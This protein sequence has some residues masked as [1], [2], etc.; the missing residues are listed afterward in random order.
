MLVISERALA[1]I[2]DHTSMISTREITTIAKI[3]RTQW[4]VIRRMPNC[5][6]PFMDGRIAKFRPDQ[7]AAHL[8]AYNEFALAQS[9]HQ[10]HRTL[11]LS[12]KMLER[13]AAMPGFPAPLGERYGQ[14]VYQVQAVVAFQATVTGGY[15][16]DHDAKAADPATLRRRAAQKHKRKPPTPASDG[17]HDEAKP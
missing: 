6:A 8:T 10:L 4:A 13:W 11:R 2:R 1:T 16:F 14:K 15:N 3:S 7:I 5:P 17:L 9:I 12:P